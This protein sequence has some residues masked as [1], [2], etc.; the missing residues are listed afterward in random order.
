MM[1]KS[2]ASFKTVNPALAYI[3]KN[4][5][6]DEEAAPAAVQEAPEGFKVN[7]LFVET[8]SKR[9]NLLAQ[10]SVIEKAKAR[11]AEEGIS[12][13]ELINNALKDY[14]DKEE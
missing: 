4:V 8:K 14:L 6:K 7:P 2:K 9:V 12:L 3:S 10:P 11:A 13:N 5:K 1:A